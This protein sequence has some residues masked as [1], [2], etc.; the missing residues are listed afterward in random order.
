MIKNITTLGLLLCS[1]A[2]FAQDTK[3]KEEIKPIPKP[4]SFETS[5]QGVFGGKTINY[6]A[7]AKD[8]F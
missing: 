2:I 7:T 3:E 1:I 8:T 5:H 6:K 4:M